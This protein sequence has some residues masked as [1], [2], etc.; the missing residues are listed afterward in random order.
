LKAKEVRSSGAVTTS[1]I[2]TSGATPADTALPA[3][4]ND[5]VIV[6]V[7]GAVPNTYALLY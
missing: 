4:G 3:N 2:S 1:P 7:V 6:V 5:H